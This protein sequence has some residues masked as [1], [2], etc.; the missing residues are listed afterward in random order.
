MDASARSTSL[1]VTCD[2]AQRHS[3]KLLTAEGRLD[4]PMTC[5]RQTTEDLSVTHSDHI[6][7][8]AQLP[9]SLHHLMRSKQAAAMLYH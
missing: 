1:S 2:S 4:T 9:Q 6:A 8:T 7:I 3:I 5:Y